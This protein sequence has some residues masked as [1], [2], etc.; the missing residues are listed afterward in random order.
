MILHLLKGFISYK[1]VPGSHLSNHYKVNLRLFSNPNLAGSGNIF[2]GG[3]HKDW[4]NP[5][6]I[7]IVNQI[8]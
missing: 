5:Y 3:L 4:S 2:R 6:R 1:L 7:V 8:E